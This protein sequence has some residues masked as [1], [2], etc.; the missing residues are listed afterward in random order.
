MLVHSHIR[1]PQ[2]HGTPRILLSSANGSGRPPWWPHLP[3]PSLLNDGVAGLSVALVLIPQSLAYAVLAG[4]PPQTGLV[5]AAVAT[6][7]AAPFVSSVWL[8]TGPV[9]ITSLL[10]AGAL[11]G[12]AD[13]AT[14]EYV[15]LAAL[16]AILVGVIRLVIG[17]LRAG[18]LAYLMSQPVLAGFMPGAAIVIAASQLPAAAGS[19]GSAGGSVLG[20]ALA[21]LAAPGSWEVTA[22]AL[23]IGTVLVM[24]A[25]PRIHRLVPGVLIAVVIGIIFSRLTGYA[26]AVVGDIPSL[27]LGL[28]LGLPW[29]RSLGLLLPATVIALVGFAEAAAISRAYATETRT[30]WNADREF[31]SQ[32]AANIASGL[33]GGFPAGGSFSRSAVGRIAGARTPWSGVAAGVFVLAFLPFADV[34]A[35]LPRAVLAGIIIGAV[36]GLMHPGQLL[37]LRHFSSP[38][39]AIGS[40]TFVLTLALAPQIHIAVVIGVG[41][42]IV[43]H[44]RRELMLSVP[45]W[46]E[47]ESLHL[48]PRGVL[49]FGSAHVLDNQLLDLLSEHRGA[50]RL[51]VH[52]DG[53]GRVD[54]TGALRARTLLTEAASSG[55]EVV[56]TDL[57]PA[58]RRILHRV[59]AETSTIS[60]QD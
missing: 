2:K 4:M 34:L 37:E 51:V 12:M 15:L 43:V 36:L 33:F 19:S 54:V 28:K 58:C 11:A 39:F 9:A 31:L 52:M 14:A 7:A 42:A 53:L 48:R 6:I 8:Q 50:R 1:R 57:T 49:Y 29:A 40:A 25:A 16:L 59:L 13:T 18:A 47:D 17:L 20:E 30:R 5:V 56:V 24:R 38:Q 3:V 55:L 32:G 60:V 35:A 46:L 22:I 45:H 21:T 27:D 44:L 10:T 41:L 26:G 23:T